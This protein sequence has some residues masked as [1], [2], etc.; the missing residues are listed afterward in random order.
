MWKWRYRL[1]SHLGSSCR[2]WQRL[3]YSILLHLCVCLMFV[4]VL[5]SFRSSSTHNSNTHNELCCTLVQTTELTLSHWINIIMR[6]NQQ[7]LCTYAYAWCLCVWCP[8]RECLLPL[9]SY[10]IGIGINWWENCE[11]FFTRFRFVVSWGFSFD[12][13]CT[14]D[15]DTGIRC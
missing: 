6:A 1:M 12:V 15:D 13:K 11:L 2:W 5:D 10:G 8:M 9:S 14:N 7:Q 4:Y 3:R